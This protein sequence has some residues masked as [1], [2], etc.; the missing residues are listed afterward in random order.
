MKTPGILTGAILGAALTLPVMAIMA[1]GSILAGLAFLPFSLFDWL[2]RFLPGPIITFGIDLIVGA[3]STFQLGPTS[4]TAKTAEQIMSLGL[5]P[6]VGAIAGGLFFALR[7]RLDGKSAVGLPG[8][9]VGG[10]VAFALILMFM[11]VPLTSAAD[12]FSNILWYLGLFGLWGIVLSFVWQELY[13]RSESAASANAASAQALNRRQFLVQVGAATAVVTVAGSAMATLLNTGRDTVF[14]GDAEPI[15]PEAT[16]QALAN[17]PNAGDPVQPVP[18]TRPEVTPVRQHY[19]IDINT[20]P[21]VVDG[22]TWRLKFT[23][24]LNE[25]GEKETLREFTLDE[26]MAFDQTDAYITMSCISNRVG[27][28]L[29][30]TTRWTGVQ[31][32]TLLD[33]VGVPEGA[34]HLWF[35]CADGFYECL[36]LALVEED[37]RIML[38]YW[39]DGELLPQRN[40]FPLRIHIPDRFGMKQ[41]KWITEIEFRDAYDDGYW[42]E[43]GWDE[44][45]IVRATSVIDTVA[46][47]SVFEQDGRILVPVGGIAWA[48]DRGISSVQV[49]VD[50]GEWQA[51]RVRSALSDRAWQLWRFEWEFQPGSHVF[52]VRCAETNLTPQ[53]EGVRPVRPSGA[54]GLHSKRETLPDSVENILAQSTAEATPGQ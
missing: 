32:K 49:R 23:S 47:G 46:V 16:P 3:I 43:R 31:F 18:G 17:L 30:S 40:G 53:L 8:L 35:T 21:P 22:E 33:E 7:G 28:D 42:V 19:R 14:S 12:A 5:L 20:I 13:R 44:E 15:D 37:E 48:G 45:A 1:L 29:I 52:E 50:N 6:L 4:E 39:W 41:P 26:L 36:D 27:G 10:L 9:I 24:A 11:A 2:A 25:S 51:A 38:A 54:T 34:T